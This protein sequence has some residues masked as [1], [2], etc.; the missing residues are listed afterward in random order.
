MSTPHDLVHRLPELPVET[1]EA[2]GTLER[3][4]RGPFLTIRP[5]KRAAPEP[6]TPA[7]LAPPKSSFTTRKYFAWALYPRVICYDPGD[8]VVGLT[9]DVSPPPQPDR[10]RPPTDLVLLARQERFYKLSSLRSRPFRHPLWCSVKYGPWTAAVTET[11][12]CLD[13]VPNRWEFFIVE[14]PEV[15]LTWLGEWEDIPAF[16]SLTVVMGSLALSSQSH[17]CCP[18]FQWCPTTQ[19]CIPLEVTCQDPIPA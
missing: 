13:G 7:T 3:S 16:P 12:S 9:M 15:F 6:P 11:E 18:G 2:A 5:P 14:V 4:D 8:L 1:F 19:S 10:D 17:S